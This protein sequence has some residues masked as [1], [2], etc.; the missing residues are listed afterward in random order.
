M[1]SDI[2]YRILARRQTVLVFEKGPKKRPTSSLQITIMGDNAMIDSLLGAGF[3]ALM[4]TVGL[5][6]FHDLGVLHVY[7]AIT[8]LH[9]QLLQQR[10]PLVTAKK[11]RPTVVDG[12][13]MNWV[14]ISASGRPGVDVTESTFAT[15]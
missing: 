11:I 7:A 2:T 8:D 4:Q 5:Q 10:M 3:Y 6:P 13:V 14:E 9:L 15:L 12:I 1:T